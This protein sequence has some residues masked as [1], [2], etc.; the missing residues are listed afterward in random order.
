MG[1]RRAVSARPRQM[2][3]RRLPVCRPLAFHRVFASENHGNA[4]A[5]GRRYVAG[6]F[7]GF[8]PCAGRLRPRIPGMA[9]PG[10]A[11]DRYWHWDY[12]KLIFFELWEA[13]A[14]VPAWLSSCVLLLAW[15]LALARR[16]A[17]RGVRL[18]H[19]DLGARRRIDVQ[20]R[21]P[22]ACACP[23]VCH[24]V[25]RKRAVRHKPCVRRDR[26]SR[27]ARSACAPLAARHIRRASRKHV[28]GRGVWA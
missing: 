6:G 4:L 1:A 25:W 23:G 11:S 2:V 5:L 10:V 14:S 24:R 13:F 18:S 27:D 17:A 20:R 12:R 8:H 16:C 15:S 9:A 19:C 28:Y 7:P 21:Y 22:A 26:R 3:L